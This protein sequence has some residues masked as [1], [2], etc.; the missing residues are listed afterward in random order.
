MGNLAWIFFFALAA[1]LDPASCCYSTEKMSQPGPPSKS[2]GA[3][4]PEP[5]GAAEVEGAASAMDQS[6]S[7]RR[8]LLQEDAAEEADS[9]SVLEDL[10]EWN[11][12]ALALVRRLE[13]NRPYSAEI[14][15]AALQEGIPLVPKALESA[16]DPAV[17][18][19]TREQLRAAT[20]AA[21]D[22]LKRASE[23]L[24]GLW[25]SRAEKTIA[26]IE[27]TMQAVRQ[28]VKDLPPG[29]LVKAKSAL[30][31]LLKLL[32]RLIEGAARVYKTLKQ[33]A[34]HPMPGTK[35][36]KKSTRT[37]LPDTKG[38]YAALEYAERSPKGVGGQGAATETNY[39]GGRP[40][41][42]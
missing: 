3:D 24:T 26:K 27:N 23:R 21:M 6:G 8:K 28:A 5:L 35:L 1:I 20:D 13:K 19:G 39:C 22:I 2:P 41:C 42:R 29:A 36:Y 10:W 37:G 40:R 14:L 9:A 15:E 38:E 18:E 17:P 32:K 4:L 33:F 12:R 34:E 7:W 16:G 30:M 31:F 25:T 11:T